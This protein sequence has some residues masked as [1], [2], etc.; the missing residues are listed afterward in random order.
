MKVTALWQRGVSTTYTTHVG[1]A[2]ASDLRGVERASVGSLK[3]RNV[4]R[5][6][7]SLG[8]AVPP[9]CRAPS[10]APDQEAAVAPQEACA[11][12]CGGAAAAPGRCP[13]RRVHRAGVA[14]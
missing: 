1:I 2:E 6:V 12:R 9:E 8:A 14:L 5:D 13:G 11:A 10:R 4:G 3:I 7:L